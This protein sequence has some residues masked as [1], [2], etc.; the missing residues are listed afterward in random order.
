M[1][2]TPRMLRTIRRGQLPHQFRSL[3]EAKG[4][5]FGTVLSKTRSLWGVAALSVISVVTCEHTKCE[6]D[7]AKSSIND[8]PKPSTDALTPRPQIGEWR[9]DGAKSESLAPFLRGLG[10]PSFA[11]FFVDAIR[12]DLNITVEEVVSEDGCSSLLEVTDHT[13]F[14]K[15]KTS[16][17]LGAGEVQRSSKTGRK[18]FMLSGFE[19]AD[20]VLNVQCRLFQRGEASLL[21]YTL[22]LTLTIDTS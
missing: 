16:I 18:Q 3:Y 22:I 9:Q 15:N 11:V 21:Q 10:V 1:R 8:A 13:F 6:Q 12:T 7:A 14:G 5:K 2:L 17:T 20:G 4:V 19:D